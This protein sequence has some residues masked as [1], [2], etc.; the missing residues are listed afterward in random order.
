VDELGQVE[1]FIDRR[2]AAIIVD[3]EPPFVV[4]QTWL[5]LVLRN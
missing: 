2:E 4:P 1:P 3:N 5:P